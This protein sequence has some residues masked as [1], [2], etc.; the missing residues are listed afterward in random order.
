MGVLMALGKLFGA[1]PVTAMAV[2][3]PQVAASY[4]QR[5][6]TTVMVASPLAVL[7][8]CAAF[9]SAHVGM[10]GLLL[11]VPLGLA[12]GLVSGLTVLLWPILRA[13]W[14]W[15]LELSVFNGLLAVWLWVSQWLAWWGGLA[16]LV[17]VSV[18]LGLIGAVRRGLAAAAWCAWD[19]HRLR[20]SFA[21]IVRATGRGGMPVY[22][23]MLWAR[24]TLAGEQ[25][26]VLLRP[27]LDL[28]DLEGKT[29]KLAVA[30]WASEVRVSRASERSAALLRID[31]T[32]RDPLTAVVKSQLAELFAGLR[33]PKVAPDGGL[34]GLAL[35]FDQVPD[36]APVVTG[37]A[38]R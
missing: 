1:R 22:P 29:G 9:A 25:V 30:C 36:P 10:P 3:E 37:R 26:W 31:V 19:R 24:P 7:L 11:G 23:L 16:V 12:L 21:R 5:A 17:L 38:R 35:D 32:R 8:S 14:W 6:R 15:A 34:E 20:L 28:G 18:G 4:A 33:K 13:V 2:V 27:G